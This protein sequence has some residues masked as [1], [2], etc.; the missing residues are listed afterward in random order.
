MTLEREAR[1][2]RTRIVRLLGHGAVALAPRRLPIAVRLVAGLGLMVAIGT[3]VLSL[4]GMT[5]T[6]L[7]LL[8]TSFMTTS[9]VTVTGLA[10]VPVS[11]SFTFLGQIVILLLAQMGGVGFMVM[12]VLALRLA[13]QRVSLVDRLALTSSIGLR[14]P[15]SVL[16]IMTRATLFILAVEGMGAVLLYL[17]WTAR[18]IVLPG[19]AWF[20]A[21][22]HSVMAFCNAGFDLFSGNTAYGGIPVDPVTLVIMG[23]L[24]IIGGL[25]IPVLAD[26]LTRRRGPRLHLHT[27]LVLGSSLGLVLVGW[28][29]LLF[30][31]FR[32]S[33]VLSGESFVDRVVIAWFQ[34]VAARTAGFASI[35]DFGG[36][37]SASLILLGGLMFVGSAPASMGGGITT[38][39]FA[40]LALAVVSY[41]T[42]RDGVYA[43]DRK[44]PADAVWRATFILVA[45]LVLVVLASWTIL[46]LQDLAS[47]AVVFEVVSA[48]STTGLSLGITPQLAPASRVLIM[49]VMFW[50]RL[51]SVTIMLAILARKPRQ[52]LIDYPDEVVL[53]G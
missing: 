31:E 49:L 5:T 23:A 53:V 1:R 32:L 33:G 20:Y 35:S 28:A 39:S 7:S 43:G 42:G 41:A 27:R 45:G 52:R 29:G 44:I 3:L 47:E 21:I 38:G 13:G 11:T 6:P 9:A 37:H 8:D 34:S 40:V 14:D 10:V 17:H 26:L 48:F 25:G 18:G 19:D 15:R 46:V 2:P 22:F 24:I 51:G 36:L 50:G 30:V 4:R 16:Q 12:V